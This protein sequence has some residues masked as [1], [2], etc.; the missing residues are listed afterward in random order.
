MAE[1]VNCEQQDAACSQVDGE[2][3]YLGSSLSVTCW[4]L[5]AAATYAMQSSSSHWRACVFDFFRRGVGGQT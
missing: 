1:K 4:S 3:L 2:G 5:V